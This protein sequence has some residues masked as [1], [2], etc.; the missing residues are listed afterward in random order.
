L[1][2]GQSERCWIALNARRVGPR[3]PIN[4][5]LRFGQQKGLGAIG[6][7]AQRGSLMAG[8]RLQPGCASMGPDQDNRGYDGE[9]YGA[10]CERHK[11]DFVLRQ[12]AVNAKHEVM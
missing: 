10:G 12:A 2:A 1:P 11:S 9:Q 8:E 4:H 7:L 5:D 6:F 3:R